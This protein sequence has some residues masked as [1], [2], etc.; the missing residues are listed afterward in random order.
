MVPFIVNGWPVLLCRDDGR[1]HAVI[2][3]CTHAA[4][5][6]APDG[7]VRRGMLMCPLHGA[8][9]RLDTGECVG[10]TGY[11]PLLVYPLRETVDG[12]LEI[13]IPDAAPGPEHLPVMPTG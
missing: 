3:R 5:T 9:F 10:A 8:R 13:A 4:A 7:R 6:F 12:W 2:N 11:K 1:L